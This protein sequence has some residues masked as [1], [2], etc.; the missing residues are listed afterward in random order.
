MSR[1]EDIPKKEIIERLIALDEEKEKVRRYFRSGPGSDFSTAFAKYIEDCEYYKC[2]FFEKTGD[3][4]WHRG[5]GP[6]SW[7]EFR[8]VK[9][10]TEYGDHDYYRIQCRCSVQV[11]DEEWDEYKEKVFHLEFMPSL[12]DDFFEMTFESWIA[13]AEHEM[14]IKR[15]K[16]AKRELADHYKRYSD[17]YPDKQVD[18]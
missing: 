4:L 2:P 11:H 6:I 13:E 17:I 1:F 16:D 15:A 8:S 18:Q 10:T 12:I 5:S 3:I 7:S 14:K 9:R